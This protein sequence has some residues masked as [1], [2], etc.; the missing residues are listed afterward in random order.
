MD[1]W[2]CCVTGLI[3][4]V[5]NS[6]EMAVFQLPVAEQRC[7]TTGGLQPLK[8]NR[9]SPP[10]VPTTRKLIRTALATE[11]TGIQPRSSRDDR[12]VVD[13]PLEGKRL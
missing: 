6:E 2:N 13:S 9:R 11:K 8:P 4:E 7:E 5:G 3:H 1:G 10:E 12:T